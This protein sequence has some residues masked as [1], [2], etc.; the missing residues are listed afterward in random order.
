MLFLRKLILP[1][2][3]IITST[4]KMLCLLPRVKSNID[5]LFDYGQHQ[6]LHVRTI[7][8]HDFIC[9]TQGASVPVDFST[10]VI[11]AARHVLICQF[12]M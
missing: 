3:Y 4:M 7:Q 5:Y 8:A 1:F 11:V 10:A 9:V 6:D 12:D 2:A